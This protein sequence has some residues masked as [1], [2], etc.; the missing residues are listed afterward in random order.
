[1]VERFVPAAGGGAPLY[2]PALLRAATVH[3]SATKAGVEG[4][5]IV[6]TAHPLTAAGVDWEHPLE[7]PAGP[8]A[9]APA[10]AARFA[11]VPGFA[12]NADNYKQVAK[13]F[14]DHL[15]HNERAE[16]FTCPALKENG[17]FGES[18][19]EFRARLTHRAREARDAEVAKLREAVEKKLRTLEGRLRS[20]EGTLAREKAESQSAKMQAGISVLGGLLG[21]LLGRKS[22]FS[23]RR[24]GSSVSRATS[25]YKQH[26]DVGVAADKV[27]AVR[28]EMARLEQEAAAETER[29]A[30]AF[31][32]AALALETL[33]LKPTRTGVQV[34]EVALLWVPSAWS[35]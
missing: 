8:L 12:L 23:T 20:A 33:T 14:A 24:A 30:A 19:G 21:G 6:R 28:D 1:V 10:A 3:F 11:E 32:P 13:D 22:S 34:D 7:L 18:E 2:Q 27:T 5:R 16:V 15:Y 4:Q 35:P 17:R 29:I 9:E 31:D 25:A 26:Q